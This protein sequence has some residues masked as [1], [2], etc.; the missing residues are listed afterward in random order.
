[1]RR[2]V[3]ALRVVWQA[4]PALR[5]ARLGKVTPPDRD[6]A[7]VAAGVAEAD[8]A[9]AGAVDDRHL[10]RHLGADR[11]RHLDGPAEVL[12]QLLHLDRRK[13]FPAPGGSDLAVLAGRH[14]VP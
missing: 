2:A 3:P 8:G 7:P 5:V 9:A 4:V 6:E 11:P 10:R 12:P 13:A 1:M 14:R